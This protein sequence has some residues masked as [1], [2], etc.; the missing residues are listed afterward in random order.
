MKSVDLSLQ[1][2]G[3]QLKNPF[4]PASGT[5]DAE[6]CQRIIGLDLSKYGALVSKGTTLKPKEGNPQPRICEH[7]G[8][9]VNSIGL[10][11]PGIDFFLDSIAPCIS[12]F[13]V[14]VILN[15]SGFTI[16]EFAIMA[17]KA[18]KSADVTALEVNVSCP[19]V[20]GGKIPFGCDPQIAAQ[21]TEV[22]RAETVLPIIV[23]L[24]PNVP[25][26]LIGQI[27]QAVEKAGA[28]AV[29]LINT[30]KVENVGGIPIG[31][32]S[33][34]PIKQTALN[35]IKIVRQSV[36]VPIIGM[37]GICT[38]DDVLKFLQAGCQAVAVGTACFANPLIIIE[39]INDLEKYC[40][41]KGIE[42]LSQLSNQD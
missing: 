25:D 3:L 40:L 12:Q 19:N 41:A 6:A 17:A 11:N 8:G 30:I 23:K 28:D 2:A 13:N 31:G 5:F 39:L 32:L 36:T 7:Q 15:I 1:L 27:A 20:H 16:E 42:N 26:N 33:G 21:V 37:G 24:T 34:Q 14:P 35:L 10:E 29:S 22:V 9:M 18:N 38:V 4:M